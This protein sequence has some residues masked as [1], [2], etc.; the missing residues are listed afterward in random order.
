LRRCGVGAARERA[1]SGEDKNASGSRR[2]APL[3]DA[4]LK[5]VD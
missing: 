3:P 5:A 2:G 1:P 4:L